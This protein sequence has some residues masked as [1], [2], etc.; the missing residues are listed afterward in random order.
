VSPGR[1]SRRGEVRA[2]ARRVE[3]LTRQVQLLERLA[4]TDPLTGLANRRGWDEQVT[5][6]LAR[7]RRSGEPMSVVLLDLDDFKGFNDER[8]HQAGDALLVEAAARW[9]AQ[10]REIDTLCRWGGD[11]FAVVLPACGLAETEDVIA[12]LETATPEP[13]TCAAGVAAWDGD[14]TAHE[15]LRRA[16]REL[17]D[18][19]RRRDGGPETPSVKAQ[20]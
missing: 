5:R 16:D 13:Q 1:G 19:K 15:L 10:L 17:L 7:A 11:E 6:E 18:A 8:G 20:L 9:T 3:E 2:L 14:E 4:R 12:R